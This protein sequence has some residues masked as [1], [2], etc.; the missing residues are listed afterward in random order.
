MTDI[1]LSAAGWVVA[2]VIGALWA[3]DHI[4]LA[5]TVRAVIALLCQY[6]ISRAYWRRMAGQADE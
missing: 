3:L 6:K 4:V 1:W 5:A 2:I